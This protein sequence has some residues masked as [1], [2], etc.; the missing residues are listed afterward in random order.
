M[1]IQPFSPR[2]RQN[3]IQPVT[4]PNAGRAQHCHKGA[5]QIPAAR[6]ASIAACSASAHGPVIIS[7]HPHQIFPPDAGQI[8]GLF[9]RRNALC[10]SV[11]A[12]TFL[13]E[14]AG[15]QSQSSALSRAVRMADSTL[16]GC[17]GLDDPV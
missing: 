3:T 14:Q 10:R 13:A 5:G 9:G 1:G 15:F 16:V 6:S 7:C 12:K 2:N 8:D 11:D 4:D 17:A